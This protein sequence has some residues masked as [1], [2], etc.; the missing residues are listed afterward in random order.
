M[1][2]DLNKLFVGLDGVAM[3]N[4]PKM[5]QFLANAL[6]FAHV[7]PALKDKLPVLKVMPWA[8]KLFAGESIEIDK[9]DLENLCEMIIGLVGATPLVIE[10]LL[11][12]LKKLL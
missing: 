3:D 7:P 4:E 6:A 1:L 12:E 5:G 11:L 10:Q 8:Y 9:S 2:V